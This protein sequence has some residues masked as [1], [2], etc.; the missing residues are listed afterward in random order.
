MATS[1]CVRI[2]W[3]RKDLLVFHAFHSFFHNPFKR[4]KTNLGE[5]PARNAVAFAGWV[6]G[7]KRG[8]KRR[9]GGRLG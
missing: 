6:R 7:A 4:V 8:A 2:A 9:N 3:Y 5:E 1:S